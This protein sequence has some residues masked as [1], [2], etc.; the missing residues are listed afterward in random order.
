MVGEIIDTTLTGLLTANRPFIA[1]AS[2][3]IPEFYYWAKVHSL[4]TNSF[5]SGV[6]FSTDGTLLITHSY[7]SSSS[8]VVYDAMTGAIKSARS[9]SSGGKENYNKRIKSMVISSG[10][11]PMAYVLSN[12]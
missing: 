9:Y 7:S 2:I 12:F 11:S 1:V 8:I 10:S 3:A 6:Q 5:F 4:K